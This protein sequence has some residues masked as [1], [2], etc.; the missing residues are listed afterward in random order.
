MIGGNNYYPH[1]NLYERDFSKLT[2]E[3]EALWLNL[4]ESEVGQSVMIDGIGKVS[5]SSRSLYYQYPK[6]ARHFTSY[7]PN[8]YLDIVELSEE[9][10]LTTQH[11]EFVTLLNSGRVNEREILN[12][13]NS[14]HAYFLVASILKNYR[15]GHHDAYLFPEFQIG[16]SYKA[17]YL[18]VG[19]GSGGWEFVFVELEAPNGK[20]TRKTGD[21]GEAIQKGLTQIGNWNEWL[22]AYYSLLSETFRKHMKNGE[23]LPD[24]FRIM[25][26]SRLHFVVVAGR[27]DN[28]NAK[29]YRNQRKKLDDEGGSHSSL[30]QS[31]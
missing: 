1:M 6:A 24:E 20:I 23:S 13:I 12:F 28:F 17:D 3:E 18:L 31:R 4:R 22:E 21:F 11:H 5:I 25:D 8:H 15:F 14:K 10:R 2:F 19:K 26:K 27:R 29:T 7:F 9:E 16:N 30:R